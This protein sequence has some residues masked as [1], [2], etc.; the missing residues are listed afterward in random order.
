MRILEAMLA[1][2]SVGDFSQKDYDHMKAK[3]VA[4]R[5]KLDKVELDFE[6]YKNKYEVQVGLIEELGNKNKELVDLTDER[7]NLKNKIEELESIVRTTKKETRDEKAL[8]ARAQLIQ[9]IRELEQDCMATLDVGFTTAVEQLEVFNPEVEL[10][11]KGISLY[12]KVVAGEFVI[13]EG[14]DDEG[15]RKRGK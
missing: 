4:L 12:Y 13:P 14:V 3:H 15:R 1:L 5:L 10:V 6:Y 7:D 8:L 2:N 9:K 11:T